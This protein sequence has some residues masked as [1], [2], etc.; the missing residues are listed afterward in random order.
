MLSFILFMKKDSIVTIL[1]MMFGYRLG[2]EGRKETFIQLKNKENVIPVTATN[3]NFLENSMSDYLNCNLN[4]FE[5]GEIF[6]FT[7]WK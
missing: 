6:S 7:H 4:S 3:N 2:R 5:V 1:Y